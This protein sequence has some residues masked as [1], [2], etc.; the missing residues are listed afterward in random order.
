MALN[1][2]F[3]KINRRMAEIFSDFCQ[4]RRA[5]KWSIFAT[6]SR[7]IPVFKWTRENY[8]T[9]DSLAGKEII[10]F[11]CSLAQLATPSEVVWQIPTSM[12]YYYYYYYFNHTPPALWT[13]LQL[14]GV[15][16]TVAVK[17]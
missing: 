5:G 14:R 15:Y 17:K 16:S 7:L 1:Y 13:Q 12:Y 10:P 9:D 3:N 2:I 4:N 8:R 11:V 6:L